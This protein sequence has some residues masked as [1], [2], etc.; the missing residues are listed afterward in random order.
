MQ[1][2]GA[3]PAPHIA[4]REIL[5]G[6]T[7]YFIGNNPEAW[8]T[9][10]ANFAGVEYRDVYPGIDLVYYGNEGRLEFD[11]I[12]SPD[13]NPNDILLNFIS[14]ENIRIDEQR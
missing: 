2:E 4:G 10:I 7:N 9:H 8:H 3:N 11:F 12:V 5:P 6:I 13:G 14:G 1:L